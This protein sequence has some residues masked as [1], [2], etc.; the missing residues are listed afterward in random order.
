MKILFI[1]E[2]SNVHFHLKQ[3]LELL[4]HEVLLVTNDG[5]WRK[6]Y[7]DVQLTRRSNSLGDGIKYIFSLIRILP[8][9]KG[10]DVVQINNPANFF[11]LKAERN[12]KLYHYLKKRNKKVFLAAYSTDYF[13]VKACVDDKIFRYSEYVVNG[14]LLDNENNR[15]EINIWKNWDK[16]NANIEVAK[17]CD[18]I[19]AC[20]YEYY[21]AYKADFPQKTTFIPLPIHV[22]NFN[23]TPK[24]FHPD[25]V[26]FF[27]GIQK[28]KNQ[29]KG[30][31]VMLRALERVKAKYPEQVE[32]VKAISVPYHEYEKMMNDSDVLLDQ[33]YSYTP[34]M[35]AL[36]AMAKG[37][38]VVGGGEPEN[39]E[40]LNEQKLRPIINVLPNEED[41][42]EKLEWLV[43]NRAEIPRL[44]AESKAYIWKH[45]WYLKVAQQYADYWQEQ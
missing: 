3:G 20:L 19:I 23:E 2:F 6:Y 8:K 40:I 37:I 30:T 36:L 1:G 5:G 42:F 16:K 18:G 29:L 35:N 11:Q 34:A 44:S 26:K 41:V 27:I 43:L 9:L 25:K 12:L 13:W 32:I 39:Y 38:V 4:G 45:H 28:N 14:A 10:F 15:N 31:D 21:A 17:S 24:T 7:S 22:A 33:L